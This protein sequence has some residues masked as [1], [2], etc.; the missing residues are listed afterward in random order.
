VDVDPLAVADLTK[1]DLELPSAGPTSQKPLG[2]FCIAAALAATSVVLESC[3]VSAADYLGSANG[4]TGVI[5]ADRIE[6]SSNSF[7]SD[8][9][10]V[11]KLGYK[12]H[13]TSVSGRFL[14][15]AAMNPAVPTTSS[16]QLI[17][18]GSRDLPCLIQVL[19]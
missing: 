3:F 17:R 16:V 11:L 15:V 12:I 8:L 4:H 2:E 1:R 19:G 9:S 5:R 6:S 18:E 14:A 7:T 10:S 13:Q